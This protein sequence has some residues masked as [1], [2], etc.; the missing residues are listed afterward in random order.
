M[1]F[2]KRAVLATALIGS[3]A[4]ASAQDFVFVRSQSEWRTGYATKIKDIE[5]FG[6]PATLNAWFLT[7]VQARPLGRYSFGEVSGVYP[8][9]GVHV[10]LYTDRTMTAGLAAGWSGNAANFTDAINKG[11]WALGGF[12]SIKF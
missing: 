11:Q 10:P 3:V 2:I 6:R 9:V 4:V 5:L 1:K 8:G 12:V 7:S